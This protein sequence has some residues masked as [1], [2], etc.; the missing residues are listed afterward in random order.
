[1]AFFQP[2]H[3][4]AG[5]EAEAEL[6]NDRRGLQPAAR[7]RRRDHV[8]GL[9]DDIEMHGVAAHGAEL[10]D[11]RLAGAEPPNGRLAGAGRHRPAVAASFTT[12]PKPSIEPG[13]SS[14]EAVSVTSLRRSAL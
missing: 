8:A 6:G 12:A 4:R 10:A 11:R 1:M 13:R 5:A 14:S 9:I 3:L 7:R 2:E